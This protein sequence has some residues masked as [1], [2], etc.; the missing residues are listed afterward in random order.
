MSDGTYCMN[1]SDRE[2]IRS[3]WWFEAFPAQ[4]HDS[5]EIAFGCLI[6]LQVPVPGKRKKGVLLGEKQFI[7]GFIAVSRVKSKQMFFW[8]FLSFS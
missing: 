3:I 4:I 5:K 2:I 6:L 1:G 7:Q 8:L